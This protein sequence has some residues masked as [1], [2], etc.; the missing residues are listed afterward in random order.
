MHPGTSW[1]LSTLLPFTSHCPEFSHVAK[2]AVREAG[3]YS[4][5]SGQPFAQAKIQEFY[6]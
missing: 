2:L 4:L 5:Y 6:D 1:N 3:N